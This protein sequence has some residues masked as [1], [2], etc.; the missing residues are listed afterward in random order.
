M[1]KKLENFIAVYPQNY[2]KLNRQND[3]ALPAKMAAIAL[4]EKYFKQQMNYIVLVQVV[5]H[6]KQFVMTLLVRPSTKSTQPV[7]LFWTL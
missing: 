3:S 1:R 2:H 7:L 6:F 5:N 4:D